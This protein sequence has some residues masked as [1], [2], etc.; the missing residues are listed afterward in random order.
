MWITERE[1]IRESLKMWKWLA[2]NPLRKKHSYLTEKGIKDIWLA[3]C[4][5]CGHYRINLYDSKCCKCPLYSIE[6][7]QVGRGDAFKLWYISTHSS[8]SSSKENSRDSAI[9]LRDAL[10]A[11]WYEHFKGNKRKSSIRKVK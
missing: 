9:K 1:A 10:Q 11:Y 3:D 8:T 6:L 7:C 4:P 2:K 5:C